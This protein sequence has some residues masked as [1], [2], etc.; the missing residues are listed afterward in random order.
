M[1]T[2]ITSEAK[3][4]DCYK[5]IRYCQVKAIGIDNDQARVVDERC[6][7]CGRCIEVCPQNA[8]SSVSYIDKFSSFLEGDSEVVVSLAPSYLA[9]TSFSTPWK[10]ISALK[11]TGVDW[12]E[13]TALGAEVISREY[14]K[15]YHRLEK[16]VLISSCCPTIV[17]LIEKYF[18]DLKDYL[19]PLVSPMIA[20]AQMIKKRYGEGVKVVFIGPCIS[21][22]EE[23]DWTSNENP[24]DLVLDFN[25]LVMFF[26]EQGLSVESLPDLY[27]DQPSY[28]ARYYPLKNGILEV[29]GIDNSISGDVLSISGIEE[30]TELFQDIQEGKVKPRFVEAM[31]CQGGCIGGPAMANNLSIFSRKRRLHN[32]VQELPGARVREIKEDSI[33]LKRTYQPRQPEEKMPTE[34]EIREILAL[35]GKFSPEDETNCG[36]CG[37]PSCREK[38]IA[39]YQGLAQPEMCVSY[40]REKAESLS[41]AVVDSSLN[42]IIIVNENMKIQEFNPAANKMFNRKGIKTKGKPLST[43]VDPRDYKYVWESKDMII[44]KYKEYPEY[45]LIT[46][47]N[48]YPLEKYGV[49]I[50]IISDVTEE[51]KRNNEIDNMKQEALNR[52]SQVIQKQM[53]VAQEIAGLLGESTAETK[54]TLLELMEIMNKKEAKVSENKS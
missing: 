53:K 30:A 1:G 52:A 14:H 24:V 27:P 6:I 37:Y 44:D 41:H 7:L 2:I 48:I 25:E 39:V 42:G 16:E 3:C 8:K 38:A 43:F 34:E 45:E 33:Q 12:V 10:L 4:R 47:E 5:C 9:A 54:A 36:G 35:T 18:P 28:R 50:A 29:S 26:Q 20:H 40:M 11:K 13:E 17:N 19:A 23:P 49:V 31:A 46:R 32:F 15:L 21:K 22:K 51:E